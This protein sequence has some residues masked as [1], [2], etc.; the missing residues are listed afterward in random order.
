MIEVQ[1]SV[2][3]TTEQYSM[4]VETVIGKPLRNPFINITLYNTLEPSGIPFPIR[5]F[6]GYDI[7]NER[8]IDAP[9]VAFPD[10][11]A[12]GRNVTLYQQDY[13]VYYLQIPREYDVSEFA[14]DLVNCTFNTVRELGGCLI[15]TDPTK[16]ASAVIF[17]NR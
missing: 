4:T 6:G 11:Y 2:A 7:E 8:L 5:T 10:D 15:V 1:M 14:E 13:D 12:S 17:A 3:E 16:D 9:I